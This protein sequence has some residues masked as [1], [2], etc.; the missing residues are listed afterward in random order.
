MRKARQEH[1]QQKGDII[2][3]EVGS[4]ARNVV[5]GKYIL[6]IGKVVIPLWLLY[7]VA[8]VL[9]AILSFIAYPSISSL[10]RPLEFPTGYNVVVA[11]FST[12]ADAERFVRNEAQQRSIDLAVSLKSRGDLLEL[13]S[14]ASG[15]QVNVLGPEY[16]DSADA[17]KMLQ[18]LGESN[19]INVLIH[20]EI[21]HRSGTKWEL[22][23]FFTVAERAVERAPELVGSYP[24]G[25]P[26]QYDTDVDSS[27]RNLRLQ[28]DERLTVLVQMIT[29]LSYHTQLTKSAYCH[30]V[31]FFWSVIQEPTLRMNTDYCDSVNVPIALFEEQKERLTRARSGREVAYLFLG[32]AYLQLAYEAYKDGQLEPT[33]IQLLMRAKQAYERGIEA[34]GTYIPLYTGLAD[35]FYQEA[36]LLERRQCD[37]PTTV[38]MERAF[39]LYQ[40]IVDKVSTPDALTV[41]PLMIS[42]LGLARIYDWQFRCHSNEEEAKQVD[43]DIQNG[44][45]HFERI[46]ELYKNHPS[47][48]RV[49]LAITAHMESVY[50]WIAAPD[51]HFSNEQERYAKI[52]HHLEEA[53]DLALD[54][55]NELLIEKV[56]KDRWFYLIK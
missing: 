44:A 54:A 11:E 10:F 26:I 9:V 8:L 4:G 21:I 3:A 45:R 47:P 20:G 27:M 13:I 56:E 49:R 6:Q 42:H 22:T 1:R 30:A 35:I 37:Q 50:L 18:S 29:G 36:V 48:T 34:N 25:A 32:H 14:E 51:R 28:L 40:D 39:N 24:L 17:D 7:F 15:S 31:W 12:T 41:Y 5:V 33:A 23:P 53:H 16:A 19:R 52:R 46:M 2:A 43:N 55:G 38:K